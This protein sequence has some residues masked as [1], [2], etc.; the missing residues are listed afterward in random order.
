MRDVLHHLQ[1]KGV[2]KIVNFSYVKW[3]FF[4]GMPVNNVKYPGGQTA[5][6]CAHKNGGQK[7]IAFPTSLIA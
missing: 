2:F 5:L 3:Q 4:V 7:S 1:G 6:L